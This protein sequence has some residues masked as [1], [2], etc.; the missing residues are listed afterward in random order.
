MQ[1]RCTKPDVKLLLHVDNQTPVQ[2][3]YRNMEQ[4]NICG[5]NSCDRPCKPHKLD[6]YTNTNNCNRQHHNSHKMFFVPC[7]IKVWLENKS[8]KLEHGQ[9]LPT[10]ARPHAIHA[11]WNASCCVSK[12]QLSGHGWNSNVFMKSI[13]FPPA[14]ETNVWIRHS[15]SCC[16]RSCPNA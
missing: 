12:S 14:H 11:L 3:G 5:R 9:A 4:N 16:V 15:P 13:R 10:R 7:V 1:H 8:N 6:A 2:I